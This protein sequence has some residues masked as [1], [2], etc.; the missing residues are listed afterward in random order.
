VLKKLGAILLLIPLA[1]VF[2]SSAWLALATLVAQFLSGWLDLQHAN[3]LNLFNPFTSLGGSGNWID[4]IV[5]GQGASGGSAVRY[6]SYLVYG[7]I[8]AGCLEGL[9]KLIKVIKSD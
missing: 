2:L 1:L 6:F 4:S 9:K 8:C 3:L 5:A 7:V